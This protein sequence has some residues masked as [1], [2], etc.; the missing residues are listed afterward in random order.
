MMRRFALL[1]L[2]FALFG[3][4]AA[5]ASACPLCKEAISA[6]S[7]DQDEDPTILPKAYNRSIYLML[8]VPFTTLVVVGVMIG[9]GVRQNEAYLD[10]MRHRDADVPN[11][12]TAQG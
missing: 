6:T 5:P 2:A 12:G 3:A 11:L 8:G 1:L 7:G 10:R 4:V 9:R